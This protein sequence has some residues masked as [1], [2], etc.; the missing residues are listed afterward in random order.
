M[1]HFDVDQQGQREDKCRG[2]EKHPPS[3]LLR[4]RSNLNGDS[5]SMLMEISSTMS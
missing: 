3:T 2:G 5:T 1:P 4:S